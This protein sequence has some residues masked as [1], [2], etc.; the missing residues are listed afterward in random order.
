MLNIYNFIC[1]KQKASPAKHTHRHT[2]TESR[3]VLFRIKSEILSI[4]SFTKQHGIEN[5]LKYIFK[6]LK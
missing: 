3:P 4:S 5:W 2:Y 1:Q 6:K